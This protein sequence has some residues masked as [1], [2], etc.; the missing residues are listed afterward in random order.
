MDKKKA[1][2]RNRAIWRGKKWSRKE[3][4]PPG[5]V[6]KLNLLTPQLPT[7][8]TVLYCRF[9]SSLLLFWHWHPQLAAQYWWWGRHPPTACNVFSLALLCRPETPRLAASRLFII[10]CQCRLSNSVGNSEF[11]G[12][13]QMNLRMLDG[14]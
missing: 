12:N 5:A 4:I 11:A 13:D 8:T 2:A 14:M 9:G 10:S 1:E 3:G 7:Q 6:S